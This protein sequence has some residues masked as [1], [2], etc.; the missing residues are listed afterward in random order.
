[1]SP[2][3]AFPPENIGSPQL[4]LFRTDLVRHRELHPEQW[5]HPRRLACPAEPHRAREG[6]P[7]GEGEGVHA[8]LRG[9]LGHPLRV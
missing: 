8:P 2:I 9:T 3:C 6:V 1:M 5:T 4:D 7:V